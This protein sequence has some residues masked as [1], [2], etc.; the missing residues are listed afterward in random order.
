VPTE[1]APAVADVAATE[2][3]A[4]TAVVEAE[5]P[6][7]N[8]CEVVVQESMADGSAVLG[9]LAWAIDGIVRDAEELT[10]VATLR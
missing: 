7:G 2:G 1:Q 6:D 8:E 3:D 10:A 5:A 4:G 9:N